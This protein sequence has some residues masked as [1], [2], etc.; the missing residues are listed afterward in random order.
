MIL[1]VQKG[2]TVIFRACFSGSLACTKLLRDAGANLSAL[3]VV[4]ARRLVQ[5]LREWS[6][7]I[8]SCYFVQIGS[9]VLFYAAFDGNVDVIEF[10]LADPRVHVNTSNLVSRR[11]GFQM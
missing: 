2:H 9:S 1:A 7:N 3:D 10:L 5:V 11:P 8:Y 4:G 6:R